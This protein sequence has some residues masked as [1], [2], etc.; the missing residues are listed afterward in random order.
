MI[1]IQTAAG[2]PQIKD[3]QVTF[4]N[5]NG[6]S[7]IIEVAAKTAEGLIEFLTSAY[8][9]EFETACQV[10]IDEVCEAAALYTKSDVLDLFP[11]TEFVYHQMDIPKSLKNP[12]RTLPGSIEWT[13]AEWLDEDTIGLW[14]SYHAHRAK[15][16]YYVT[17]AAELGSW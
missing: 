8:K 9:R 10:K 5:S 4:A 7:Q 11:P 2:G 12:S 17:P 3:W 13:L 15:P 6:E 16:D 1:D 14:K